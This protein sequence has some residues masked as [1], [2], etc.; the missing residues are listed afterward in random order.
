M[1]PK[2][3]SLMILL[4][5]GIGFL[6]GHETIKN[7]PLKDEGTPCFHNGTTLVWVGFKLLGKGKKYK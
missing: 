6:F 4:S 2:T 1:N 7:P 3:G 5:V